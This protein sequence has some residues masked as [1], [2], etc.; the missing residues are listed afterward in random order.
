MKKFIKNKE[1]FKCEKCGLFVTGD[2]YTNHCPNCLWSKHADINPGDRLA[3]CG[4]MM[5]PVRS[6]RKGQK[7]NLVQ[8]CVKCGKIKKNRLSEDDNYDKV[9]SL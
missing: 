3:D 5:E 8:K 9:I 4:G 1:D 6:E 7:E 2:G